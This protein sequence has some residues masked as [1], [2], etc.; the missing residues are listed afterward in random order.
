MN[1]YGPNAVI[2]LLRFLAKRNIEDMRYLNSLIKA[3]T[4][5]A[6]M[7]ENNEI[8]LTNH[9]DLAYKITTL[10]IDKV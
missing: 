8:T 7:I 2:A 4:Y 10:L 6:M 3:A 5:S 1:Y 9:T